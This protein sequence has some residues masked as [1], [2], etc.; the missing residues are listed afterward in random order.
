VVPIGSDVRADHDDYADQD[1]VAVGRQPTDAAG[2]LANAL[3]R[4]GPDDWALTVIY[5]YPEPAERD[6]RWLAVHAEH[7]VRHHL[8]EVRSHAGVVGEH[9]H[10]VAD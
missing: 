7:E 6:I 8:Q 3:D 4:L 2:L 10:H 9:P 5:D 1:V